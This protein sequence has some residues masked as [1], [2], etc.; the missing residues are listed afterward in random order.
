MSLI[1]NNDNNQYGFIDDL[2]RHVI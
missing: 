1:S 2:F